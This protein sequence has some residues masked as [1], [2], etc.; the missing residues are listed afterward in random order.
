MLKLVNS[1]ILICFKA[2][3]DLSVTGNPSAKTRELVN[4]LI[5]LLQETQLAKEN[6]LKL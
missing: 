1:D 3:D 6:V 5:E 4:L 2:C